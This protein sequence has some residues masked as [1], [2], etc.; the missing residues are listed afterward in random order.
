M[1]IDFYH[2]LFLITI[3]VFIASFV[4]PQKDNQFLFSILSVVMWILLGFS[5][6][7]VEKVSVHVVGTEI[8]EYSTIIYSVGFA[9]VCYAFT[10][11][12]L[13]YS[14]IIGVS[15][16]HEVKTIKESEVKV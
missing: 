2:L 14:I 11:F 5:S 13:I 8:I 15:F 16:L 7:Y 12:S 9:Y 6:Y 4:F 10:L 3:G 1:H